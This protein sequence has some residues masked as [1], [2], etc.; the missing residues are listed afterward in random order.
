ME[1]VD[2]G[3]HHAND[4]VC[5]CHNHHNKH[6]AMDTPDYLSPTLPR[7]QQLE[8]GAIHQQ[9]AQW[10]GLYLHIQVRSDNMAGLFEG[11]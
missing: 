4:D 9:T 3:A 6:Y 11:F 1:C 5:I 10:P 7:S 8:S 2:T